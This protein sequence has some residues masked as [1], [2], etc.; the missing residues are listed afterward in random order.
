MIR[1]LVHKIDPYANINALGH[2]PD[3]QGWNFTHPIFRK[4]IDEIRPSAI[5]EVGTWKGA[6]ALHMVDCLTAAGLMNTEIC[7]VDTWL[8]SFM[9][10]EI[11]ESWETDLKRV[12]GYPSLYYTFL[13]NVFSKNAHT[14]ITPVPSISSLAAKFFAKNG[15]KFDLIYIDASHEY[16]DVISD[17]RSYWP[18][19]SDKGVMFGDDYVFWD[20]VNAAVR[21]MAA[22]FRIGL[23]IQNEK[24]IMRRPV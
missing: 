14:F 9:E 12:N 4:L 11:N 22:Q 1:S 8:G 5:C 2:V 23:E 24:W 17:I 6:S 16:E 7:C 13:K 10:S 15:V 19:L 3:I 21:E 20:G 18:L